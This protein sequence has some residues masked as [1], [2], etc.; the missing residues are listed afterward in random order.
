MPGPSALD[1]PIAG[2]MQTVRAVADDCAGVSTGSWRGARSQ[3]LGPDSGTTIDRRVAI[4]RLHR[5]P[6]AASTRWG[7]R[8]SRG[9]G[10]GWR[11]C[12]PRGRGGAQPS[13]GDGALGDL[14]I[15]SGGDPRDGAAEDALAPLDPPPL[16]VLPDDESTSRRRDPGH[17]RGPSRPRPRRRTR[18][19][20]R[21]RARSG[22]WNT[23][24]STARSRCPALLDRHP[25]PPRRPDRRAMPRAPAATTPAAA[26]A[27]RLEELFLPFL[28][29]NHIPRPRLNAWLSIG[30]DRFQVDCLWPEPASSASS[31][32]SSPTA[33]SE[34]SARTASATGD[35]AAATGI[36]SSMRN[37]TEDQLADRTPHAI[38]L[39]SELLA[40]TFTTVRDNLR[41]WP[42]PRPR[43]R[44]PSAPAS[45]R[46]ARRCRCPCATSPTA[47][48]SRRRC[49]PRSSAGRPRRRSRSRRRSP[50]ASN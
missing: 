48:A 31:T 35:S 5:H 16:L 42:P 46:C 40:A 41:P 22:R 39:A 36:G 8:R 18:A 33:R 6:S 15:G 49:C 4:G 29:A 19:R 44:L 17:V 3:E 25:T 28:D 32:A 12:S 38:A 1:R 45:A 13:V 23:S 11:R 20:R 26:S 9:G 21:R 10:G 30:D 27:A 37:F 2:A 43:L 34:P 50:P 24:G 14:G 47:P 7:T